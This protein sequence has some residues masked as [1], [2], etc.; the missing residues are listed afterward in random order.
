MF[1]I[2]NIFFIII[3]FVGKKLLL[4]VMFINSIVLFSILMQF[5]DKT[6]PTD[7]QGLERCQKQLL[8][9]F[10]FLFTDEGSFWN[11]VT[12]SFNIVLNQFFTV[13]SWN[14]YSLA[15]KIK[16]QL[17]IDLFIYLL[18]K[19]TYYHGTGTMKEK[20]IGRPDRR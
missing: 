10:S 17:F 6:V 9:H 15:T 3:L 13:R 14:Y 18:S 8:A 11:T 4:V 16:H 19:I 5:P 2:M 7:S 1:E 20:H 12:L